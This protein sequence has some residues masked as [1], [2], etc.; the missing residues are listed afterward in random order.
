LQHL[1]QSPGLVH[2]RADRA[3]LTAGAEHQT[4]YQ[5]TPPHKPQPFLHFRFCK[6]CGVRTFGR[7]GD[8]GQKGGFYFINVAALD[9]DPKELAAAPLRYVDGR[10]DHYDQTPD[11]TRLL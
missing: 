10:H 3:R 6:T 7:G 9:V 8:E 1:L 5:W 11:D 4:E 2:H